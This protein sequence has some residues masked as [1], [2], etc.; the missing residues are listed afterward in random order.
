MSENMKQKKSTSFDM[1]TLK[2]LLS[3]MK[4][5][6]TTMIVVVICIILSAVASAASSMLQT[7]LH[8]PFP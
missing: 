7:L 4:K 5:Y 8:A 6:K 3:Y 2:R 1:Q